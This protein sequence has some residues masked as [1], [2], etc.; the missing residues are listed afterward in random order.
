[1]EYNKGCL[2]EFEMAFEGE[3]EAIANVIGNEILRDLTI[4]LRCTRSHRMS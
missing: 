4:Q 3:V 1:V 2:R